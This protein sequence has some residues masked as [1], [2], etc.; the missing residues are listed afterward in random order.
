MRWASAA[1]LL[2]GAGCDVNFDGAGEGGPRSPPRIFES[3]PGA[4]AAL[5]RDGE[6]AFRVEGE[7]E[8]SLNLTWTFFADDVPE[9]A[10]D[11]GTGEFLAVWQMPWTEAWSGTE[12]DVAFEV[13]DGTLVTDL[14]WV[15]TVD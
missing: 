9:E 8:D 5:P 7:D 6:L 11:T 4:D 3:S 12:V 14:S 15:V 13:T 1:L 2:L 10:G